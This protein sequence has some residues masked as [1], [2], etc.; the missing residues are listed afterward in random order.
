MSENVDRRILGAFVCV[1]AIMDSATLPAIPVTPPP[2]LTPPPQWT[3]RSNQGGA[4][5]IFDGPG[6]EP[7][8]DDF[9]PSGPWPPTPATLEVALQDPSLRYLPRRAQVK[10][11]LP[12]PVIPPIPATPNV[13]VPQRVKL[14]PS[15]AAP[16]GPNWATIH[17][18]VSKAGSNPVQGLPWAV[19]RV[20]RVSDS[21]VLATGVTGPN[22]EALLAVVGL[23]LQVNTS[24]G[25]AVTVS[26]TPATVTAFFDPSVLKQPP[27]WIPDPDDILN[28]LANPALVVS[29]AQPVQLSAGLETS[30]SFALTVV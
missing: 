6:F 14:Y 26:T 7:Q 29:T 21:S 23:T 24:G 11:P 8:T 12:V 1:D 15:A 20:L 18:S 19:L 9:I 27:G 10:A 28:N 4:Y 13:F 3:I 2:L 5:V 30:M 22:G 25:G 17:A 16:Y